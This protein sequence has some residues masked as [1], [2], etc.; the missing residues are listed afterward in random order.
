MLRT[1]LAQMAAHRGRMV[2]A[3]LAIVIGTAFVAATILASGLLRG[4]VTAAVSASYQGADVVVTGAD[5]PLEDPVVARAGAADLVAAAEGQRRASVDLVTGGR[6]DFA[7][8]GSA[9]QA[10][11]LREDVVLEAGELPAGPGGVA[12]DEGLADQ[13]GLR[14]GDAVSVRWTTYGPAQEVAAAD[15]QGALTENG[16]VVRTDEVVVS[17]LLATRNDLTGRAGRVLGDPADVATWSVLDVGG[18]PGELSQV[19]VVGAEGADP[20][21]VRASVAAA[22]GPG[23]SVLT[24]AQQTERTVD[25]F[26]GTDRLLTAVLLAFASLA[27]FVAGIVVTNTLAVLVAQRRRE[28]ALLRCVG[29]TRGQVRR[30]VLVE[31]AVLGLVS[32]LAGVALGT[33]LAQ[34]AAS[35]VSRLDLGFTTPP[36][37]DLSWVSVLVPL[38]VGTGTTVVAALAP[39]R[40]AT[41]VAPLAALRPDL[42]VGDGGRAPVVRTVL[43][44]LLVLGG[45]GLLVLGVVLGIRGGAGVAPLALGVVG[46]A[47]SF[48]GVLVGA[49]VLLPPVLR[50]LGWAAARVG[51]V[52]TRLAADNTV[53][54]PRRAAVTAS[55]LLIGVTL[56]TLMTVGTASVQATIEA[57]L[58]A[59]HPVDITVGGPGAGVAADG[60]APAVDPAV[61]AAV[62]GVAGSGLVDVP[63]A[64]PGTSASAPGAGPGAAWPVVGVDRAAASGVVRDPALLD[65]LADGTVLVPRYLRGVLS[66]GQVLALQGPGG[67]LEAEVVMTRLPLEALVV[68]PADLARLDPGAGTGLLWVDVPEGGDDQAAVEAVQDAVATA[69]VEGPGT[70]VDGAAV[71]RGDI[72]EALDAMLGIVLSL[73][74][75]AVVIALIGVSNTLSLSVIERTRESALL[76]AMGLTRGQL[77]RTLAVEGLL[78]AAVGALVGVVLG[79]GYGW[80]GTVTVFGEALDTRLALPWERLGLVVGVALLA[81]LL[82]SV[83]PAQRAVRTPP[84]AALGE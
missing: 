60:S 49:P 65:G 39:A 67:A 36:T 10:P 56:V 59:E 3:G 11:Q 30:T 79:T 53:R 27:V 81:G 66:P 12:V 23:T 62:A 35:V 68:T 29:A 48:T 64:L 25:E 75:V 33:A 42:P 2:A 8:V 43:T 40:A 51:G 63:L 37:V 58:D 57:Q 47:V 9:P 7:I 69:A 31:A 70:P 74:G 32:S 5:G 72:T 6:S 73:L 84:A 13:L 50:V 20:E 55:A 77:R 80:A 54:N 76:R 1:T 78:L 61:V 18:S 34:A 52:P 17:G 41:R 14:V 71:Q 26:T 45:G 16:T 21:Q 15:A 83:L 82:A 38:V 4:T 24:A 22:L 19:L 28:L 44:A 46:G